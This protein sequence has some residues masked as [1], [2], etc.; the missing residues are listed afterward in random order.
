M[1]IA[2]TADHCREATR[3]RRASRAPGARST[4]DDLPQCDPD[5][6]PESGANFSSFHLLDPF[7]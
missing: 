2:E 5:A 1:P 6:R 3:P 7:A 4:A